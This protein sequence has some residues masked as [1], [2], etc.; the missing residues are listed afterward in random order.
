MDNINLLITTEVK[1]GKKFWLKKKGQ[2]DVKKK[3][4]LK[5]YWIMELNEHERV[6]TYTNRHL[7]QTEECLHRKLRWF[8]Y[9]WAP[10]DILAR[11]GIGLKMRAR[12]KNESFMMMQNYQHVV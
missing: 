6:A 1:Y 10:L 2:E 8:H 4:P 7:A 5:I 3:N 12:D 11:H 9:L